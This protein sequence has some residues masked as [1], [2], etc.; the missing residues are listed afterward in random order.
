MDS[1]L[2]M[3]AES[4]LDQFGLNMTVVVNMLFRQ[5]VREQAVPLSLTLYPRMSVRDELDHALSERLTGYKG[6]SADSVA[7]DMEL[8]IAEAGNDVNVDAIIDCRQENRG[9]YR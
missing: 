5:I 2:K 8:M 9:L 6:R 7:H 1:E 4:I 3:Q